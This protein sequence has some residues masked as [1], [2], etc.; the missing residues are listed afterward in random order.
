VKDGESAILSSHFLSGRILK[1]AGG[2]YD[3]DTP[4]GLRRA[5]LRGRVKQTDS[6]I[7]SVGDL[8]ELESAADELRIAKLLPRKS[9]LTR[10]GVAKRREQVIVA[11]V[12]QVMVVASDRS[13]NP[14]IF[15]IDRLFALATLSGIESCLVVNK[16][17]LSDTLSHKI[18]VYE[19]IGFNIFRTSAHS[20]KG[21]EDLS[22]R[23]EGRVTVLTGQSGVGKSS[24]LNALI[25]GLDLRVG[26]INERK[27]RGRHT[28]VSSAL[29]PY[30][31]G[32][33]VADTPGLQYVALWGVDPVDVVGGFSEI[34]VIGQDCRFADCRHRSEPNCA[35][36]QDVEKGNIE[37]HRYKSY[38][39]LLRESEDR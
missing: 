3:V 9:A 34:A 32:G 1:I 15:M 23:L 12:D 4:D 20:G 10:H 16:I 31:Q 39:A 11:N 17:D 24:L 21:L 33:Y 5:S 35:V 38:L 7:V 29:Y 27:G 13:P 22:K 26:K 6:R 19:K 30:P 36:R 37:A 14:D 2:V 25:P 28:T 8:V 18:E